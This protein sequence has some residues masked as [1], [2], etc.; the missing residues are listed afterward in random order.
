LVHLHFIYFGDL[1]IGV[2]ED[3]LD[4]DTRHFLIMHFDLRLNMVV[5][6]DYIFFFQFIY[7]FI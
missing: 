6:A 3:M 4:D 1:E 2:I 7:L 5:V